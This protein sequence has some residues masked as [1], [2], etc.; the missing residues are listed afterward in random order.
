MR[1]RAVINQKQAEEILERVRRM[2]LP[3]LSQPFMIVNPRIGRFYIQMEAKGDEATIIINEGS[4]TLTLRSGRT[5]SSTFQVVSEDG[6]V[7]PSGIKRIE[8]Q[9]SKSFY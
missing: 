3:F 7:L 4:D 8:S 5:H 2:K 6:E 1:T 9:L